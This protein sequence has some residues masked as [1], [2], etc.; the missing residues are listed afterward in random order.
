MTKD[1]DDPGYVTSGL[2]GLRVDQRVTS[3]NQS[4]GITA[5]TVNIAPQARDLNSPEFNETK[6]QILR[7]IPKTQK[8]MVSAAFG[9]S[10]AFKLACQ[11]HDFMKA[12]GHDVQDGVMHAM[13]SKPIQ[14]MIVDTVNPEKWSLIVGSRD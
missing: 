11:I 9:D 7:E 4:G 3:H 5:H 10:E 2:K 13:L 8:V 6:E 14:G 12:N 1:N